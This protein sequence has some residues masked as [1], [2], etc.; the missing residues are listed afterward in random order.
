M[1]P[2]EA[3]TSHCCDLTIRPEHVRVVKLTL[4]EYLRNKTEHYIFFLVV[5]S[6][7][8]IASVGCWWGFFVMVVT[9]VSEMRCEESQGNERDARWRTNHARIRVFVVVGGLLPV[10]GF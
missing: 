8:H 7:N 6:H 3:A 2:Q 10:G 1:T 5:S 9:A 4:C